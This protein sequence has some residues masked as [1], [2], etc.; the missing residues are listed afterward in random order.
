M[1]SVETGPFRGEVEKLLVSPRFRK[2]GVARRVMEKLEEVAKE[3]GRWN[4]MLDTTVGSGAESVYHKLGW[5][6]IGVVPKY[7]IHPLTGELLGEVYFY[8]NLEG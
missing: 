2:V 3:K 1:P 7:G 4:L 5:T 8:K 6:S